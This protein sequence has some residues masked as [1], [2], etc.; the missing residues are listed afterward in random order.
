MVLFS[1]YLLKCINWKNQAKVIYMHVGTHA[2][3]KFEEDGTTA[4]VPMTRITELDR[5]DC[6]VVWSNKKHIREF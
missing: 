6:T 5:S 1:E 4:V 3:V 2:L